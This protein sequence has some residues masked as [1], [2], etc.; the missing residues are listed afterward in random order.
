MAA[1]QGPTLADGLNY[2][3]KNSSSTLVTTTLDTVGLKTVS[4]DY[5][6]AVFAPMN[7][8]VH[9]IYYGYQTTAN[10]A[11]KAVV[12]EPASMAILAS[13]VVALGAAR[14]KLGRAKA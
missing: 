14:R 7:D 2:T 12:P 11:I 10:T 4:G 1:I 6:Y 13:G 3:Q 8:G 9:L 5:G